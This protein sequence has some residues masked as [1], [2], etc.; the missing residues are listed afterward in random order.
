MAVNVA[1][2]G[3]GRIGRDV[4]RGWALRDE[5]SFNITHIADLKASEKIKEHAHLFK[6]DSVYRKFPGEVEVVEDGFLVNGNKVTVIDGKLPSEMNW[7]E[8]GVDIVIESTGA[9]TEYAKAHGHI[10]AGAKKVIISAPAK[11]DVKTIVMGVNDSEYDSAVHDV[12]SNAS[13]TTNCLAPVTKVILE[14]F[15]IERGIMTTVHAYT[16][17]QKIHDALHKDMRRARA[18][19]ENIIPTTTGAAQ[20]VAKVI[21]EVEGIL[22]GMAM[23]V[24]VPTGS[25]VD[26]TFEISKEATVEE[27]NAAIKKASENELKGVLA[28][29]EEDIVS[30]DIVGDPHSSIFDSQLTIVKDRLV[31]L[32]SW[33]DNEWGYSQRVVDLTDKVSKGL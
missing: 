12:I 11:G 25:V 7:G 2:M 4:L 6:Y 9:F 28:Y 5:K 23:R 20:A 30:S 8:L 3:F 27:I 31:K 33:Y 10:E 15:G 21:P 26:V 19:A 1:I 22:T 13:C 16:N 24:P 29:T 14:N 32:V 18:G 17:D